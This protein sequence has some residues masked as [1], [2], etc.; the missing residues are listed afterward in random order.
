MY[1]VEDCLVELARKAGS[2]MVT[3]V[4]LSS[5]ATGTEDASDSNSMISVIEGLMKCVLITFTMH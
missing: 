2:F 4:E 3:L 5:I 1:A